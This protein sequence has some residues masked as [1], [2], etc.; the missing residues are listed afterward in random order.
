L[1]KIDVADGEIFK[2]GNESSDE[3]PVAEDEE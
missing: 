3:V 1:D 2:Y